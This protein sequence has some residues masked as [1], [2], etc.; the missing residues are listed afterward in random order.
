MKIP[1]RDTLKILLA[2]DV[3][4]QTG[5]AGSLALTLAN[6]LG[7]DVEG[8]FFEDEELLDTSHSP[9]AIELFASSAK[10]KK[11]EFSA[12]ER[13]MRAWSAQTQRQLIKQANHVNV[14]CSF[15]SV[16]G[17]MENI[18]SEHLSAEK[19]FV[20]AGARTTYFNPITVAHA[21]YVL[22]DDNTELESC[23]TVISDLL[24]KPG[25]HVVIVDSSSKESSTELT[26]LIDDLTGHGSV[27]EY[28]RADNELLFAIGKLQKS[29]P[30]SV[31]VV[32]GGHQ[33]LKQI[34]GLDQLRKKVS[35]PVVIIN[36]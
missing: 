30:C 31:M 36:R 12:I 2:L 13:S 1:D 23:K 8:L 5:S 3:S 16:R 18:L 6:Y 4:S 28:A 7:A 11:P 17:Y 14:K 26:Q 24:K 33:L 21:V 32:P 29:H 34:R 22:V 9:Y 27:V 15:R 19:Y 10:E 25:N 20:L 35:C